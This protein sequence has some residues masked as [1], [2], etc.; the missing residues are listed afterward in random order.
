MELVVEA[1]V[2]H[3]LERREHA[4]L[5]ATTTMVQHL[6]RQSGKIVGVKYLAGLG[7]TSMFHLGP[8]Q[9]YDSPFNLIR[10]GMLSDSMLASTF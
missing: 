7:D 5:N 3:L 10:K 2:N 6:A 1:G 8:G 9:V 4:P